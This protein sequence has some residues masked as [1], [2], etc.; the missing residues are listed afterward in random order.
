MGKYEVEQVGPEEMYVNWKQE[1]DCVTGEI[2]IM[3]NDRLDEHVGDKLN[4]VFD[5]VIRDRHAG[6]VYQMVG[7]YLDAWEDGE[8]KV[9]FREF[10]QLD[11]PAATGAGD[12]KAWAHVVELAEERRNDTDLIAAVL[13]AYTGVDYVGGVIRGCS[14]SDWNILWHPKEWCHDLKTSVSNL[15][16]GEVE[17]WLCR[18]TETDDVTGYVL[19]DPYMSWDTKKEHLRAAFSL[20]DGE[21]VTWKWHKG[22]RKVQEFNEEVD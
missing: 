22:Y 12:D 6:G 2:I 18:D 10:I 4:R 19:Y 11:D 16:W 14:Q 17:E 3:G 9:S 21:P 5:S 8:T 1:M 20:P 7:E 15:Y 13:T